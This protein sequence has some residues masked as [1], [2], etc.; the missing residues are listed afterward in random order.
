MSVKFNVILHTNSPLNI[1]LTVC[2]FITYL[3]IKTIY[4]KSNHTFFSN[5]R[6]KVKPHTDVNLTKNENV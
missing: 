3:F 2:L 1:I 6:G 5:R 4:E